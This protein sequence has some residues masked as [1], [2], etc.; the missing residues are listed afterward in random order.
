MQF[1]V[2][3]HRRR[4]QSAVEIACGIG[5]RI[6]HSERTARPVLKAKTARAGE[7]PQNVGGAGEFIEVGQVS[8]AADINDHGI[9]AVDFDAVKILG[10]QRC[11]GCV[12][13][14]ISFAVE[15]MRRGRV[16]ECIRK[17]TGAQRLVGRQ[18]CE[19]IRKIGQRGLERRCE[20]WQRKSSCRRYVIGGVPSLDRPGIAAAI[21]QIGAFDRRRVVAGDIGRAT[22]IMQVDGRPAQ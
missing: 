5:H 18:Y 22:R 19:R 4:N 12:D 7:I 10:V 16:D 17:R 2:L 14:V 8:G 20:A 1:V 11:Y 6:R 21:K 13:D 3:R 15:C 9:D